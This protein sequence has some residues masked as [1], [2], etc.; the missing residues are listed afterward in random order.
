M[1][2]RL[3]FQRKTTP[4][5]SFIPKSRNLLP[6]RSTEQAE[7]PLVPPILHDIL[8][9]FQAKLTIGQ[10][11]DQYEQEADRVELAQNGV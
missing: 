6:H 8:P 10:S 4:Q 3:K 11:H 7:P 9:K 1:N 5:S 2:T